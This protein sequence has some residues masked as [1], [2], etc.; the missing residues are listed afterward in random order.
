V[1]GRAL[2]FER[3][4][5]N[6]PAACDAANAIAGGERPLLK[7]RKRGREEGIHICIYL[8]IYVERD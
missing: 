7:Y 2:K 6:P 4:S 5:V 1:L 3:A 8:S